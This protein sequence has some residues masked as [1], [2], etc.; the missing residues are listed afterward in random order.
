MLTLESIFE[1][2]RQKI[3]KN[4][5]LLKKTGMKFHPGMKKRKKNRVNTSSRDEILKRAYFFKKFWPMYL[6]ML[7][8]VNVFEQW[9]YEYN[10]T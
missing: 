6:N 7:S 5:L 4:M 10:E 8:K 9:K 1:Y 3:L 2:I